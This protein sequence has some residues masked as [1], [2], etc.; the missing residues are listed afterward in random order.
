MVTRAYWGKLSDGRDTDLYKITNKNGLSVSVSDYGGTITSIKVPDRNGSLGE[1]ILSY[2][3]P[4]DYEKHTMYFGAMIGRF[5]NRIKRGK[6]SLDGKD[7]QVTINE[8][9]NSLHGGS[10]YDSKIWNSE[11]IENGVAFTYTDPDGTDGFP[12]TVKARIT[13]TLN[14][15]NELTLDYYA[16]SD[17]N[18]Y[19]NMTNHSYF[20][21]A[22][23][24]DILAHELFVD[25]DVYTEVDDELIPTDVKNVEGTEFDFRKMRPVRSGSYDHNYGLNPGDGIKARVHDPESGRIISLT[26]TLPA[27]QIYVGGGIQDHTGRGGAQYTKNSGLCLETQFYPD[28]PNRPDFPN[29][30]LKAGDEYHHTTTLKFT[31]E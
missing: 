7:Y 18:T 21:L 25:A 19:V 23:H 20:N 8:G 17:K 14:D 28:S 30:V 13:V 9:K 27:I 2:D 11:I 29:A 22:G 16:V 24:G 15:E 12:G 26:T 10:G 6:F 31:A 1:I 5:A 3:K 4:A